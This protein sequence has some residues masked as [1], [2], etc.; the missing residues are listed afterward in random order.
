MLST[1]IEPLYIYYTRQYLYN[2][3]IDVAINLLI[4]AK[5]SERYYNAYYNID[6]NNI[7]DGIDPCLGYDG[8]DTNLLETKEYGKISWETLLIKDKLDKINEIIKKN[9]IRTVQS[10]PS[11]YINLANINS[12]NFN[13]YFNLPFIEFLTNNHEHIGFFKLLKKKLES[14][15][16]YFNTN[17]ENLNNS[18]IKLRFCIWRPYIDKMGN[19]I[20]DFDDDE[21]WNN[22]SST[23]EKVIL[24][25][26]ESYSDI[27]IDY[28]DPELDKTKK[29]YIIG[30]MGKPIQLDDIYKIINSLNIPLTILNIKYNDNILDF[31]T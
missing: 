11:Y 10:Q 25:W 7:F 5:E 20:N 1:H 22:I 26:Y 24:N 21:F 19:Q 9:G 23:L 28:I 17:F 18:N 6:G 12:N 14:F 29:W 4:K 8:I 3:K 31:I 2:L 27:K 13:T 30:C 16:Y 15:G